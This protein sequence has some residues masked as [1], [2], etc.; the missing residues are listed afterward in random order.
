[1]LEAGQLSLQKQPLSLASLVQETLEQW[2]PQLR[3]ADMQ[4]DLSVPADDLSCE[5]RGDPLRM[6]QI[7]SNLVS[8]AMRHAASGHW[9]GVEVR[10]VED[11]ARKLWVELQICDAGP[12]LPQEL[13]AH[14]FQRFALAPGKRRREGSGLGLS[15]VRALTESQGGNVTTDTA[16]RG[17]TRF[18]LRF[19]RA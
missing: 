7:I 12:G 5:V 8:N 19:P 6:R 2:R 17:G 18:T 10:P 1:M 4:L 15:I 16:P 14:P 13:R 11:D 9:L 3:N